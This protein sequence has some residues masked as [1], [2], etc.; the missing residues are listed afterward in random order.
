MPDLIDAGHVYIAL[1]PLYKVTKGRQER[2]LKDDDEMNAYF[3][4]TGLEGSKLHVAE[5]APPIDDAV[6]ERIARSYLDVVARLE[7]LHRIYPTE[8]TTALIDAPARVA[9]RPVDP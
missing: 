6:L 2:Y 4:Q 8:V 1:P 9:G 7:A 5:D 3:L